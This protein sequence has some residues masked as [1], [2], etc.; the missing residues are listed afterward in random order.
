MHLATQSKSKFALEHA[1]RALSK[2]IQLDATSVQTR[3]NIAIFQANVN[4]LFP[5]RM[6]CTDVFVCPQAQEPEG[7]AIRKPATVSELT[8]KA[9]EDPACSDQNL[10]I[11]VSK[12][13]R[14]AGVLGVTTYEK[15]TAVF[16][17]CGLVVLEGVYEKK[18]IG[19]LVR[20]DTRM[21]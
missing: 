13:E 18:L 5:G 2:A 11:E 4:H 7:D 12:E 21:K 15:A 8:R 6:E 20:V 17:T 16:R 14:R 9:S 1:G 10:R 3:E 19:V